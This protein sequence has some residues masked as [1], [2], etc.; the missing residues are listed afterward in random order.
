MNPNQWLVMLFL[1]SGV[2]LL[3]TYIAMEGKI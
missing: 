3:F 2:A 1:Y